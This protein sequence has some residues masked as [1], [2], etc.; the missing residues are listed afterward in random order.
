M[1][2]PD[3]Q[4]DMR[5][6]LVSSPSLRDQGVSKEAANAAA[7]RGGESCRAAKVQPKNERLFGNQQSGEPVQGSLKG[8]A[9]NSRASD[10]SWVTSRRVFP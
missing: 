5:G 10:G 2:L 3:R 8:N 7:Y 1:S 9:S 6:N 4:A